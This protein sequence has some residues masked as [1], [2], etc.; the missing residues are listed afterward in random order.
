LGVDTS[1]QGGINSNNYVTS[2]ANPASPTGASSQGSNGAATTSAAWGSI[3]L[4]AG[5][6]FMQVMGF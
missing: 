1:F 5:N 2:V 4:I 3:L 6:F